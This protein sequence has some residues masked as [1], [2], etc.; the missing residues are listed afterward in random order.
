MSALL[1]SL[2]VIAGV[3]VD[4]RVPVDQMTDSQVIEHDISGASVRI[5]DGLPGAAGGFPD[6]PV[7]PWTVELPAGY[8]AVSV[9]ILEERWLE[10]STDIYIRPLPAPLPLVL[11]T[12]VHGAIPDPVV[13]GSDEFWP[14]SPVRLSG[15]GYRNGSPVAGIVVSPYRFSPETGSLQKLVDLRISVDVEE[16]LTDPLFS[17]RT[18]A[19]RMLIITDASLVS[20]FEELAQRRTDEGI[21]TEI[22]TL[23]TV[24][25]Q[26]SGRDDAETIRNYII[27]YY[28][29]NGLDYVLFGGDTNLVPFRFA[30]AMECEAGF[31]PREDSL[32]CDLYFS[33]LDGTWDAN[34]NDIFGEIDDNVDLYPDVFV[35]RV[36][37]E[38]AVEADAW[39]SKQIA[40][41]DCF[42]TDHINKALFL[43]MILWWDPYTDSALSKDLIDELYMPYF[44]SITKLYESL[45]N[46]NVGTVM[47]AMNEGQNFVNHDGHAWWNSLGVGEG[48]MNAEH[49]DAINSNGRYSSFMY[50]IGCW[51]AA[52]DFD[53]VA[54]HFLT[55]P[56]GCGVSYIGNSSY[57]WG[58]PGNPTYGYSDV[59]DRLYFDVLYSDWNI[60]A[61]EILALA[62]E[63]YIPYSQWENVYRWH[64][65][66]VNLLGDPSFRPYRK[67][68]LQP[69]VSCPDFVCP[70][71]TWF[72]VQISGCPTE[73]LTVCVH[74]EGSN[75]FVE[76]LD[77]AGFVSFEL[78]APPTGTFTVTVTGNGIR[79]TSL[80]VLENTGPY[81]VVSAL[82]IDDTGGDGFLSPGDMAHVDI[83]LLN[84]GTEGLTN[85]NLFAT[86]ESGPGY[87]T[88]PSMTFGDLPAGVSSVGSE[89]MDIVVLST[90]ENGDVADI[91]LHISTDQGDWD[92][93]LPLLIYAPGLYFATY[94]VDDGNNDIPEPGETFQLTLNIANLGLLEAENVS[95]VMTEYP[96]WV[97]WLSDSAW[98]PS[99]PVNST[100]AFDLTCQLSPAA[101]S[102]SF[103]WLLFE[104][105]SVTASYQTTDTLRLTVGETGIINDV[106]S[107]E[108]G[109]THGGTGDLWNITTSESHSPDHSWFCGNVSGY[110]PG[111]DC[112][113]LSPPMI[114]A[115]DAS[116]TFWTTFD[117]AIYGTDGLYPL[118]HHLSSMTTDTLDFIG[119]GGALLG[120]GRGIGTGWVSYSYDLSYVGTG[121]GVQ[122]EFRF[123]S[124][125]D[126]D[127][128]GGFYVDDI[129]V[130]GG[131]LGSMG[132][133]GEGSGLTEPMGLPFPNPAASSFS[134]PLL[135]E[136]QGRWTLGVYDLTGRLIASEEGNSPFEQT[137]VMSTDG[138]AAGIYFLRLS[139]SA[140]MTRRLVIVR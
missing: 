36:T 71:T 52:F 106:E 118:L 46:E 105:T 67:D 102:P 56:V 107:G 54:E 126:G 21:I 12:P 82:N 117:V 78:T 24:Y 135:L 45:G 79:R 16:S 110:T 57:G 97:S 38:D 40:Y 19:A 8:R 61:G 60:R 17:P 26:A 94:A 27:D 2:L 50:S 123:I 80:T 98:S 134:I 15:T 92:I 49:L 3:S 65:Y 90:A 91:N 74:D 83:T 68:P 89:P 10:V 69:D 72:P 28:T 108:N 96:D 111:M 103:P 39:V 75:Y 73:G 14:A 20:S 131:Y 114:L 1:L 13:Y 44:I 66:D 70:N 62:K 139:G 7:I 129:I 127:V 47:L 120:P 30:F 59:L 101:P 55:N 140:S 33:D 112:G 122:I 22:V 35:G 42:Y 86:M 5:Y 121:E 113:L 124:D 64:E 132:N 58:S 95:L 18:D 32:P 53:A 88:E 4:S 137:L 37:V 77:N 41:E 104:L 109:W 93:G 29:T 25:A 116:L 84:Q 85:V 31:A 48:Y 115:P 87:I 11:E 6:L 81:P 63:Y 99:I 138:L 130:E 125:M 76:T 23:T 51:S 119:S 9:R 100:S 43:A 128:G 136:E 133:P 34:G